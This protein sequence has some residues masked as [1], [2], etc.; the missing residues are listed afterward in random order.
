MKKFLKKSIC[1]FLFVFILAALFSGCDLSSKNN[2]TT[3]GKKDSSAQ[4][5]L[6]KEVKSTDN[7]F[8]VTVPKSWTST[9]ELNAEAKLQVA[10]KQE[11]KY[12]IIIGESNKDVASSYTLNDYYK[13]VSSSLSGNIQNSKLG[14]ATETMINGY[15]AT[16]FQISGEVNKIKATYLVT[17][18]KGN[19]AFYQVIFWTLDSNFSKYEPEF[20][21]VAKTFKEL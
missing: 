8:K 16:Q 7:T 17:L 4:I 9:S 19:K 13:Q 15:Q 20:K 6:N 21:A 11:E 1:C 5:D 18:I 12:L 10:N 14:A 2:G 3:A